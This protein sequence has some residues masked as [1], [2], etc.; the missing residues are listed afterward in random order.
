MM[1]KLLS[2]A[3]K[4]KHS[5]FYLWLLNQVLWRVIPFN[6]AHKIWIEE[7]SDTTVRIQLPYIRNNQNHL[8]GMHACALATL[9][10][11]A[12][13]IGLIT[14]LNPAKFRLIL[15]D[16]HVDY[17]TQG[18]S[19]VNVVFTLPET[20]FKQDIL[21]PLQQEGVVLKTFVTEAFDSTQKLICTAQVTWQLKQ[22]DK[23]KKG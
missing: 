11:Y 12:C 8:K 21:E 14:R 20:L 17:H 2:I 4:A 13:G 7:L 22:W 9:C 3:Q 15:K 5:R 16:I 10:E 1:N 19:A 23:V 6:H 18:K